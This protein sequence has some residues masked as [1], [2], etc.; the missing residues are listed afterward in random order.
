MAPIFFPLQ[1]IEQ[2]RQPI[3]YIIYLARVNVD[4]AGAE[5]RDTTR[6]R[7]YK[8]IEGKR[9]EKKG[10]G[11]RRRRGGGVYSLYVHRE[12]CIGFIGT[13]IYR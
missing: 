10:I 5:I 12:Y 11:R 7:E 3:Y 1:K 6:L 13:Y 2:G 4:T 9:I 8:Y